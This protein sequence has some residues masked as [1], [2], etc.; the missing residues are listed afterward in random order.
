MQIKI[1]YAPRHALFHRS[2]G[3]WNGA[4]GEM[5]G[6]P[7]NMCVYEYDTWRYKY[8]AIKTRRSKASAIKQSLRLPDMSHKK[9]KQ[10]K[11]TNL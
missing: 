7:R 9:T 1:K 4:V 11:Y 3:K 10:I 8:R 6:S 2:K 5:R